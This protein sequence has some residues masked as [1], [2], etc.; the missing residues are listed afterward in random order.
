MSL[1]Q[2]FG[3]GALE[4]R[5]AVL[6]AVRS[7]VDGTLLDRALV[8]RFAAPASA[9]GEDVL[10]IH[11]HGG[12]ALVERVLS[13]AMTVAG[14]RAAEPGEFTLR[15]V[16]NGRIDL[17]GAEALADLIE[18]RSEAEM[19]RAARLAD[20]ALARRIAD[21]RSR[22][23]RALALAEAHLDFADEGDVA[24]GGDD[25]DA[26]IV[27]L[28]DEIAAVLTA[29][30]GAEK[31]S[32]GF[33]VALV[34]PPN[35]GKSSLLNALAG[36]DAAIVSPEAG[37]TRDVVAV[38]IELGGYRVTVSDTA[39]L[40]EDA[41]GIEAL[42]VARAEALMRNADLVVEV[43]SPDTVP[44]APPR[45]GLVVMH[46]AD[47]LETAPL[48][49][50]VATS[51]HDPSSVAHLRGLLA[52][53]A[54]AGMTSAESALVTRA[55]QRSAL[56][57]VVSGLDEAAAA[58]PLELKAEGLRLAADAMGRMTGEIGIEDVLDDV[59]KR[60]CIGK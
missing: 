38:E 36:R 4:P 28:R 11:L 45:A 20:G 18:A 32:D 6:R 14:V 49:A 9:T 26:Q 16:L 59:F 30:V 25:V 50:D 12:P 46:K 33:G 51:I 37:T 23:L 48:S 29:S 22:L 34:G 56:T 24:G 27:P 39:G 44:V 10:E 1:A 60:F 2:A 3:I 31:L 43:R 15:A 40:R 7:P 17:P 42:G 52:E 19:R 47:L 41:A 55:R 5:R 21:W 58:G 54:R 13:D 35:A 57:G 53:H 8:I